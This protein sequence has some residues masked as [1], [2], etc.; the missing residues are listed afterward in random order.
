MNTS[1]FVLPLAEC[2]LERLGSAL[3]AGQIVGARGD[4]YFQHPERRDDEDFKAFMT[5]YEEATGD[6]TVYSVFHASQALAALEAAYMKA[7]DENGVDWPSEEQV[8]AAMDGLEFQGLGGKVTIR[9]R[10]SGRRE[11]S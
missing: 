9:V 10:Q 6:I 7:I 8:L 1:T 11:R 4:H 2:S 5:Q 3:P